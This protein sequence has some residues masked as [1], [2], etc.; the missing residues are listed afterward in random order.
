MLVKKV[1]TTKARY[2]LQANSL[3]NH[4]PLARLYIAM[5]TD[6]RTVKSARARL[7]N[8]IVVTVR[9]M[10]K[11][12]IQSTSPLTTIPAT[13]DTDKMAMV[14]QRR[15]PSSSGRHLG[16]EVGFIF[17]EQERPHVRAT[18]YYFSLPFRAHGPF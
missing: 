2:S 1:R 14:S 11:R 6:N 12:V 3:S 8:Q 17:L 7:K 16:A 15:H 18:G 10:R 4:S 9:V 5:G 13:E